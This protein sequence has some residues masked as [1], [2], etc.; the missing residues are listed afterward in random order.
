MAE[1]I[2]GMTAKELNMELLDRYNILI[3]DLTEK[4]KDN[5]RQYVRIAIRNTE[6]NDKLINGLKKCL[7]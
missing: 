4:I 7:K 1:I 5:D 6:D 3:K 2:N